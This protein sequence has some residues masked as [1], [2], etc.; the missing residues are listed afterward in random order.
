MRSL[1][2]RVRT[3]HMPNQVFRQSCLGVLLDAS[4]T[5]TILDPAYGGDTRLIKSVAAE[6]EK[7]LLQLRM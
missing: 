2:D 5:L 3:M 1:L 7:L 6:V 4:N